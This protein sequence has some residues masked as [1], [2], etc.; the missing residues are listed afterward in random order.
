MGNSGSYPGGSGSGATSSELD[1]MSRP[2]EVHN[3]EGKPGSGAKGAKIKET[4]D[5]VKGSI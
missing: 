1:E 5:A 4:Q 2:E 3:L